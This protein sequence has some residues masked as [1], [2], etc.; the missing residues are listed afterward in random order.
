MSIRHIILRGL[1]V[2]L[3]SFL[4]ERIGDEILQE[5]KIPRVGDVRQNALYVG[6]YSATHFDGGDA[7]CSKFMF[8]FQFGI[9]I[10]L[11]LS[12]H[13]QKYSIHIDYNPNCFTRL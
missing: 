12:C 8:H 10:S 4:G 11:L 9:P 7:F 6:S 3:F 2:I 5:E 13:Q 1:T